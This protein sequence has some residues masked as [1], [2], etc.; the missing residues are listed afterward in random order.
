[1]T[2]AQRLSAA[3]SAGFHRGVEG[4][5]DFVIGLAQIWVL[6]VILAAG[7]LVA[8]LVLRRRR[9]RKALARGPEAGRMPAPPVP[10]AKK[11]EK[12]D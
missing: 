8:V 10:E 5:E 9:R 4:L 1:M 12:E 7:A 3:F 11:A 2:F 6:L